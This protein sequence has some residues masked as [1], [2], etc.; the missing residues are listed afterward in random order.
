MS[1]DNRTVGIVL[2]V[3]A[4]FAL[5]SAQLI[6]KT[7]LTVHGTVPFNWS[8][9]GPYLLA[10]IADWRMWAGALGLIVSSLL[11]YAAVS[12]IPLSLAYPFGA[13]SYPLVFV[14]SLVLL[15][16]EFSWQ[17]LVGNALIV[18]GVVLVARVSLP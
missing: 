2:V 16:E 15:R 14:A 10:V 5:T 13:L 12:R 8:E 7:R 11:W 4:V 1:L 17:G 3:V 18:I 9:G 6:I